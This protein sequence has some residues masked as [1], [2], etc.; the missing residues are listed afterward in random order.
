MAPDA[1][2]PRDTSVPGD[3]SVSRDDSWPRVVLLANRFTMLDRFERARTA[4]RAGIRWVHLRDHDA[5]AETFHRRA[6]ACASALRAAQPDVQLSVNAR[7]DVAADLDAGY[8]A[9]FRG[10][11]I[12]EARARL[13]STSRIGFSAHEQEEV[14]TEATEGADYFFFSPVFPT[15]SKPGHPGVGT[16]ALRDVCGATDRPV[17]ALGGITPGRV[18]SCREAGAYGVAVLSGILHADAVADAVRAY[19]RAAAPDT[20]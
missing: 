8:H 9:G 4:V 14:T 2:S 13:G 17:Y 12:A 19:L 5:D 7:L 10:A 1:S 20:G 18:R 11:S 6:K 15:S 16:D 3:T